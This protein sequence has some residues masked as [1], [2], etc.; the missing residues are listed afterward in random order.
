MLVVNS[1]GNHKHLLENVETDILSNYDFKIF[2][3]K[4]KVKNSII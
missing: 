4:S 2:A 1:S 3:F